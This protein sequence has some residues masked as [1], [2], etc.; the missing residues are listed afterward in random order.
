MPTKWKILIV[1]DDEGMRLMMTRILTK[2]KKFEIKVAENG[3]IA[4]EILET[5]LPDLIILDSMMPKK[6]GIKTC[7]DIRKNIKF[8][9]I[10][11]LGISGSENKD[12]NPINNIQG[13]DAFLL[14]PFMTESFK[15]TIYNLLNGQKTT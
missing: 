1:D 4:D 5:Y 11:I 10:K 12:G 14:K 6:D 13:N 9:D 2:E 15:E 7:T 3:T 8:K